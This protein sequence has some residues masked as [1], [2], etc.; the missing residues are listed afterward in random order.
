MKFHD[1]EHDVGPMSSERVRRKGSL[2]HPGKADKKSADKLRLERDKKKEDEK[3][4]LER[5]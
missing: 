1:E 2:S 4:K 5:K 3:Y